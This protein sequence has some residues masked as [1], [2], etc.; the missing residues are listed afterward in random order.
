MCGPQQPPVQEQEQQEEQEMQEQTEDQEHLE[1]CDG[2][3]ESVQ[4]LGAYTLLTSCRYFMRIKIKR[5]KQQKQ[6]KQ[7]EQQKQHT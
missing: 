3:S 6:H 5:L 7:Q 1:C 4:G 2:Y